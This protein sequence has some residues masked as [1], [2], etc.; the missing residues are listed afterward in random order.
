[1]IEFSNKFLEKLNDK[2]QLQ[3]FLA[4]LNYVSD[5]YQDLANDC[6]LL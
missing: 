2:I 1:M 3:R 6:K 5:F 4:S